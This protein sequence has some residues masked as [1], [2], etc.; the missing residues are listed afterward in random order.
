MSMDMKELDFLTSEEFSREMKND[1][2]KKWIRSSEAVKR[3]SMSRPTIVSIA[4]DAG[5]VYKINGALLINTEILD[6]YLESFRL[7]GV[8]K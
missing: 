5:S 1:G 3:Y 2:S 7:P 4:R 6:F 8:V